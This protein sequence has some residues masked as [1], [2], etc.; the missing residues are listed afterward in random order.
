MGLTGISVQAD[1]PQRLQ[2]SNLCDKQ[3]G[4][5]KGEDVGES[6]FHRKWASPYKGKK[7]LKKSFL[8]HALKVKRQKLSFVI[9]V[10]V[11][12]K[13]SHPASLRI[14]FLTALELLVPVILR[15]TLLL[16]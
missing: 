15:D 8:F 5:E 6:T 2:F 13:R 1:G 4:N 10:W 12:R 14:S 7:M 11:T 16:L 3:A 9:H